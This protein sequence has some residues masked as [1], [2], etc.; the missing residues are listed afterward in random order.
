MALARVALIVV[1]FAIVFAPTVIAVGIA[2]AFGGDIQRASMSAYR[3]LMS[4]MRTLRNIVVQRHSADS[5][6]SGRADLRP[7]RQALP[8]RPTVVSHA[9]TKSILIAEQP[10]VRARSPCSSRTDARTESAESQPHP[11]QQNQRPATDLLNRHQDS[12]AH[13]TSPRERAHGAE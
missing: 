5:A 4:A 13:G 11:L 1:A 8:M 2:Q 6:R 12:T 10:L 3:T 9:C 7:A